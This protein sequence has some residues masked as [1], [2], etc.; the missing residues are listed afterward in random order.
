MFFPALSPLVSVLH[1]RHWPTGC[2]VVSN[3]K[4]V[5]IKTSRSV[6]ETAASAVHHTSLSG[7][8][9]DSRV[10]LGTTPSPQNAHQKWFQTTSKAR[11]ITSKTLLDELG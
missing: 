10:E 6:S 5:L 4:R 9:R 1:A 7:G 11:V 3:G 2:T 8:P